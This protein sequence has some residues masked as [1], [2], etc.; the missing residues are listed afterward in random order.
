[1]AL[2]LKLYNTLLL[3]EMLIVSSYLI[4]KTTEIKKERS[5]KGI[6]TSF[7]FIWIAYHTLFPL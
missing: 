2:Q 1:M 4:I 3:T 6:A 5:S 7:P